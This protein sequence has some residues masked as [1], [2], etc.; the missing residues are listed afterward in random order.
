MRPSMW[1]AGGL[2][3]QCVL[4]FVLLNALLSFENRWPTYGVRLRPLLSVELCALLA[5]LLA[6]VAWRGVLSTRAAGWLAIG[7]VGLVLVRYVDL[8]APAVMGRPVNLYW[9]GRHVGGV[10]QMLFDSLPTGLLLGALGGGMLGLL[11]MWGVV[12]W[13]IGVLS[14]GL[15]HRAPRPWVLATVLASTTAFLLHVP[16]ER[17]TRRYFA[18]P[19]APT[20]VKQGRM[21]AKVWWPGERESALG[22][23]PAFDG[24]VAALGGADVLLLFAESYGACTLDQPAQRAALAP[25]RAA[26]AEAIAASGRGVVSARF[27]SPTSGG[28]SWLS[29]A[30]VLAGVDT[31]DQA[32]YDLLLTSDRPTLVRHFA[33]HGYRTVGWMPGTKS[34]WP[35]GAFYG[36]D[37]LAPDAGIPYRG[38]PFGYWRIPDEAAMAVLHAE[39][40]ARPATAGPRPARFMVFPSTTTH[41]PFYPLPPLVD[42]WARAAGPGAYSRDQLMASIEAKDSLKRPLQGYLDSMRYQFGW[43]TSYLAGPAP[44]DLVLIIVG[45]HQPQPAVT[46]PGASWDVPVHVV[47]SQPALLER[48]RAQGFVDG[49]LPAERRLGRLEGLTPMLLQVFDQPGGQ[50]GPSLAPPGL[51][52]RP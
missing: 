34:A 49:L 14:R 15:G 2:L 24:N 48:L 17:D 3:L 5:V 22:P 35:E 42:D 51:G 40:I 41:A 39:E 31:R 1:K 27:E 37:R 18:E 32:D 10:L 33:R 45:D 29:H 21:L 50:D 47:S 36:F 28:A 44:R 16:R 38:L 8:T 20:L 11:L 4:A 6:W 52:L 9:D 30:A 46:G 43:W 19:Q 23:G 7:F 26:L 25:A 12:R 13:A